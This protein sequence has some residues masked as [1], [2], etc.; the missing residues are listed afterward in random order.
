MGSGSSAKQAAASEAALKRWSLVRLH[1]VDFPRHS[2]RQT[3]RRWAEVSEAALEAQRAERAHRRQAAEAL[4]RWN[5]VSS[6]AASRTGSLGAADQAARLG[7]LSSASLAQHWAARRPASVFAQPA[8]APSVASSGQALSDDDE[9]PSGQPL[10]PTYSYGTPSGSSS[11]SSSLSWQRTPSWQQALQQQQGGLSRTVSRRQLFAAP[12]PV[13]QQPQ[14]HDEQEAERLVGGVAGM[15]LGGSS[16][17]KPQQAPARQEWQ[18]YEQHKQRLP[19]PS[20]ALVHKLP[21]A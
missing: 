15:G 10:V 12:P 18:A 7:S 14:E 1:F 6:A 8:V 11:A 5:P 9:V 17:G 20:A 16:G 2:R 19:A 3:L 4:L 21:P 13:R